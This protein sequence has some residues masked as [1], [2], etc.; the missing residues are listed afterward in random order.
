M[1]FHTLI[2]AAGLLAGAGALEAQSLSLSLRGS[3]AVPMGSFAEAAATE[4]GTFAGARNGFG[5]GLD[6]GLGL[7]SGLALYAGFDRVEFDCEPGQCEG[8]GK[9]SLG[10]ASA[11]VQLRPRGRGI[12]Q[13]WVRGGLTFS[14]LQGEFGDSGSRRLKTDRAPGYEVGVGAYIPLVAGIALSPHARYSGQNFKCRV[15]GIESPEPS[16]QGVGYFSFGLGLGMGG[17]GRR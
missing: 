6:A 14:E 13:P 17:F 15:P 10:G 8:N 12:L 11:G 3:G 7:G 2:I 4:E 1:R 5:F 9:Y 16:E